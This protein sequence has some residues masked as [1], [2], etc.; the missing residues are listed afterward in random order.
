MNDFL[1]LDT[2][3]TQSSREEEH[4]EESSSTSNS[5][6][7]VPS[8][9]SSSKTTEPDIFLATS[10]FLGVTPVRPRPLARHNVL[11]RDR[12]SLAF[13]PKKL[14]DYPQILRRQFG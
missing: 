1:D 9:A 7:R 12:L 13:S 6:T 2:A 4:A 5:A 3:P 11:Q 8:S 14:W 10:C